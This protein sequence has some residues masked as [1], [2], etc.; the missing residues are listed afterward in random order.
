MKKSLKYNKKSLKYNKKTRKNIG[1]LPKP[2]PKVKI[3][4]S[5]K[6]YYNIDELKIGRRYNFTINRPQSQRGNE[7]YEVLAPRRELYN[8]K[9]TN[10]FKRDN[11]QDSGVQLEDVIKN[12]QRHAGKHT[13]T[14]GIIEKITGE[15]YTIDDIANMHPHITTEI[16]SFIGGRKSKKTK[17]SKKKVRKTRRKL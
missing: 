5:S 14:S 2:K 1:G 4:L 13:V 10:L 9:V 17:K 7:K 3:D 12:G 11:P 16:N 6:P 15:N 8:G